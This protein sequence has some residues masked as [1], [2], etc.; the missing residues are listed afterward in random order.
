MRLKRLAGMLLGFS[1]ITL[2]HFCRLAICRRSQK[3]S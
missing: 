2:L 1:D 3:H